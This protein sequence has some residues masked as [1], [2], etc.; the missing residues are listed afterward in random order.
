MTILAVDHAGAGFNIAK[1]AMDELTGGR[2]VEIGIIDVQWTEVD[3]S[4]CGL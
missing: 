3:R 4:V 1:G 2:A